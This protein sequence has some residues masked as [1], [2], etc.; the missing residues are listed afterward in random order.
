VANARDIV[1]SDAN[2]LLIGDSGTGKTTF[3][4]T[5]PQIEVADFDKGMASL[6]GL[7][8]PYATFK[9]APKD[10]KVYPT[11]AKQGVYP[12]GQAWPAF[13]KW[14]DDVGQ[15]IDKGTG[16]KA[17]GIDSL[18]LLMQVAMNHVL[19]TSN[20][21]SPNQGSWGAQQ[22]YVKRILNQLTAWPVQLVCTAHIQRNE[23]DLTKVTEKLPLLTGKLAGFISAY[24]DEVYFTDVKTDTAGKRTYFVQT[25][26]TPTVRQAKSRWG[27]PDGTLLTYSALQPYFAP[28]VKVAV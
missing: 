13:I 21:T 1:P 27:V 4:G 19:L 12:Y 14:L 2:I 24:F 18:S 5:V 8:V 17:I 20:Q 23:N 26:S 9:E 11:M 15:R 16:P 22:E 25:Q 10:V 7:D 6:R 28:K 3:L